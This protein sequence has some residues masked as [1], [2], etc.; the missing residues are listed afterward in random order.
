MIYAGRSLQTAGMETHPTIQN[1]IERIYMLDFLYP[2]GI[3]I[4]SQTLSLDTLSNQV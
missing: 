4:E 1:V 3:K 2:V